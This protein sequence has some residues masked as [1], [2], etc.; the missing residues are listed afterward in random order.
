[1]SDLPR[2][3]RFRDPN[4]KAFTAPRNTEYRATR[5]T[6]HGGVSIAIA[7]REEA[8]SRSA[9]DYV[10]LDPSGSNQDSNTGNEDKPITTSDHEDLIDSQGWTDSALSLSF[11]R[12]VRVVG[13]E[14]VPNF[15]LPSVDKSEQNVVSGT[16]ESQ[17]HPWF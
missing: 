15:Q 17:L 16:T 3:R 2:L 9:F 1:M 12:E 4:K 13:E 6:V 10:V 7:L 11:P 5:L 8:G 14:A